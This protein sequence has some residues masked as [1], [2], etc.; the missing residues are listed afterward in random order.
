LAG[1]AYH[2]LDNDGWRL[3]SEPGLANVQV[4]LIGTE[5]D[6]NLFVQQTTSTD[7]HGIYRFTG[8]NQ[9]TYSV[10]MGQV[11]GYSIGKSSAGFFGGNAQS[12]S[13]FDI[14]L[15]GGWAKWGGYN[16]GFV[17]TVPSP[18]PGP[19]NKVS[20]IAWN[21]LNNDGVRGLDEPSLAGIEIGLL[22]T[23]SDGSPVLLTAQTDA[24]GTYRFT[25]LTAGTYAIMTGSITSGFVGGKTSV[26]AF[27]GTPTT[28]GIDGIT[29]PGGWPESGGYDIGMV[30]V[31]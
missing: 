16:F 6:T 3:P 12:A 27:G 19:G 14:P 1:L 15:P 9:G 21:D 22:G 18:P 31:A 23:E 7:T 20:G 11:V 10:L 28:G 26:G 30:G 24:S 13:V 8:L 4:T 29:L 2:D 17:E 5:S 25:G